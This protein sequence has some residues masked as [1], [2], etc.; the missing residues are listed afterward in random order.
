MLFH[1]IVLIQSTSE[2][3]EK[4]AISK[5][6]FVLLTIYTGVRNNIHQKG[7][8]SYKYDF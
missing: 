8:M 6:S 1:C 5:E 3:L 4:L 7:M 2:H